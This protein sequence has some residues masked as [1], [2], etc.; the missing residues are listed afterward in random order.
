[1]RARVAAAALLAAWLHIAGCVALGWRF[2][3]GFS[4]TDTSLFAKPPVVVHRGG[5]FLLA[6]TQGSSPFFFEPAYRPKDDRLVFALVSTSSTGDL[7]GRPRE[8][9]IEGDANISA[10]QRGGACWWERAPAPDGTL[11]PLRIVEQPSTAAPR[12]AR[13]R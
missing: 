11:V 8:M 4:A 1:M 10:L 5:D 12:P 13:T 3:P 6:W 9:R 7:A 2:G